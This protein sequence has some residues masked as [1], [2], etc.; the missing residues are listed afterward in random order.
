[1]IENIV[2]NQKTKI[3]LMLYQNIGAKNMRDITKAIDGTYSH[4]VGE[5]KSMMKHGLVKK[6]KKGRESII[7]LT[8]KGAKIG[9]NLYNIDQEMRDKGVEDER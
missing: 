4:V 5:I 1:M 8:R 2:N 9:K 6:Q 3:L 7:T